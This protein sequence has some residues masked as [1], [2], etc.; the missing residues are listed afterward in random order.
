MHGKG[1]VKGSHW[2]FSRKVQ[3][4]NNDFS[5]FFKGVWYQDHILETS[6][7]RESKSWS[8]GWRLGWQ[9]QWAGEI[10]DLFDFSRK[11]QSFLNDFS[12]FSKGVRYHNHILE[13]SPHG[14]LK[15]CSLGWCLGW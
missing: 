11:V 3:R 7:H 15:S 10:L 5:H 4:L 6:V 14:C 1:E 13:T 2:Q 12:H 8:L 9:F